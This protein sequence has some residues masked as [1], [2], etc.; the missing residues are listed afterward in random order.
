MN[1]KARFWD[2]GSSGNDVHGLVFEGEEVNAKWRDAAVGDRRFSGSIKFGVKALLGLFVFEDVFDRLVLCF[3]VML[4]V[5]AVVVI[6]NG[7]IDSFD[8]GVLMS[9]ESSIEVFGG[10]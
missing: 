6:V 5:E 4:E 7:L 9:G 1:L 3:V 2:F 8:V 10:G